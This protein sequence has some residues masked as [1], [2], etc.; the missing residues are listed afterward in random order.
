MKAIDIMQLYFRT[1]NFKVF[2]YRVGARR[3]NGWV[4]DMKG[5]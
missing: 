3:E 1:A 2:I 5:S 4:L